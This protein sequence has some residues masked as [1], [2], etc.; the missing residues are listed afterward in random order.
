MLVDTL[1]LIWLVWVSTAD[2]Q[3]RD[4]ARTLLA[5]LAHQ[6]SQWM[7]IG[8][9]GGYAGPLVNWVWGLRRWRK[10]RLE[11]VPQW[12]GNRFVVLPNRWIVE[13]TLGWLM[14]CR[15]WRCDYEQRTDHSEAFIYRAMIGL[16][17]RGLARKQ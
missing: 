11:I 12:R 3:E 4:G 14:K 15:R 17:T 1:G 2:V 9:D 16:M 7:L 10:I 5:R 8:A 6:F 13:R